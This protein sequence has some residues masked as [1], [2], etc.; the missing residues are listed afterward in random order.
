LWFDGETLT[1]SILERI[2]K[3][4]WHEGGQGRAVQ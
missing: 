4:F 3:I 1:S 2:F